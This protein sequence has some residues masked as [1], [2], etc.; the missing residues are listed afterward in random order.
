MRSL[1]HYGTEKIELNGTEYG[2]EDFLKLCP[3]YCVPYGFKTRV[4][5]EGEQHYITDGNN[6]LYMSKTD[7][8][9]NSICDR[10]GELARLVFR[11]KAEMAE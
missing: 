1:V 7:K 10:E 3:D 5:R 6:S 8:Y 11:L 2:F 9:C 4:Y